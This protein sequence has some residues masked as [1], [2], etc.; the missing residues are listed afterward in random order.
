MSEFWPADLGERSALRG[1]LS[2]LV[3]L[4]G[5]A[6]VRLQATTDGAVLGVWGGPPLDVVTLRPVALRQP[7]DLGDVT[8]SAVRLLERLSDPDGGAVAAALPVEVPPSVQGPAWAGLLPPRTGWT[9]LA[10]VPA[11][12]VYDA[13]RVGVDGFARRVELIGE[14]DRSRAQLDAVAADVWGRPVVAGVPLRVAHAAELT[15][16]LGRDGEVTAYSSGTWRRLGCPGGSV[17]ARTDS[18]ASLD[19]FAL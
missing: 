3:A 9:V 18:G 11:G 6:C 1:Y 10:T 12:A 16:L 13:V 4:D 8:V 7:S 5:R 17:A 2:R 15:G 14:P 19:L